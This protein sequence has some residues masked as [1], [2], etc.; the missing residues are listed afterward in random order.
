M[1]LG[2]GVARKMSDRKL[3]KDTFSMLIQTGEK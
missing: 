3:E 1:T 2:R